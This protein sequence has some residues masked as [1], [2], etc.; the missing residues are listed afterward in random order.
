MKLKQKTLT[1]IGKAVEQVCHGRRVIEVGKRYERHDDPND[2]SP[3][4][5]SFNV[6]L[7][8]PNKDDLSDM[9]PRRELVGE[10]IPDFSGYVALDCYCYHRGGVGEYRGELDTHVTVLI[11]PGQS[12]VYAAEIPPKADL[13]AI[14][15][16]ADPVVI[17]QAAD[18]RERAFRQRMMSR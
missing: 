8:D 14:V 3:N 12:V 2:E 13:M 11:G 16:G 10:D 5:V 18:E 17:K 4:K 9:F 15:N 7:L 1:A 6:L